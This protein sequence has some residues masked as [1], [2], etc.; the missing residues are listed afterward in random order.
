MAPGIRHPDATDI[1]RQS[2]S[3][4][5]ATAH[6]AFV[7]TAADPELDAIRQQLQ[8]A[9]HELERLIEQSTATLMIMKESEK[10]RQT[11]VNLRGA[12]DKPGEEVFA[13]FPSSLPQ[14]PKRQ[15][16]FR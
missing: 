13:A 8:S 9:N 5:E 6:D 12:Y 4:G 3:R 10:P 2:F 16:Q 7:Q 11:F 1:S 15:V 14:P